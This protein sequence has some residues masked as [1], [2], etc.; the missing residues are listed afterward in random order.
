MEIN[1]ALAEKVIAT[2]WRAARAMGYRRAITYSTL[3]ESGASLR[4]A[5]YRIVGEVQAQS[6]HRPGRPRFDKTEIQPRLVWLIDG[7]AAGES[8]LHRSERVLPRGSGDAHG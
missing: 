4:A 3:K 7:A 5:G 8:A 6:W 2:C 1:R